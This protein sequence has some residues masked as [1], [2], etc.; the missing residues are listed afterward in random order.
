MPLTWN[1]CD[2]NLLLI[3]AAG[4]GVTSA[5]MLLGTVAATD[6]SDCHL[7]VIDGRGDQAL[8]GFEHSPWCGGVVRLHERERL[9]RLINRLADE[10]ARRN[11]RSDV[12]PRHPIVVL[13]DGLDI[14]RSSLDDLETAAEFEML[15]TI[16]ALG[17]AHDVVV[18]E[19]VRSR[20]GHP[21]DG[22]GPL[23]PALGLPP[24]RSD[25]RRRAGDLPGRG[26]GAA[27]GQDRRRL[28]RSRGAVDGRLACRCRRAPAVWSPSPVEC[29]PAMLDAADLPPASGEA[30]TRC[31]RSAC[32]SVTA[33][34]AAS[35]CP[36]ANT[37]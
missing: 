37:C 31:C 6:G 17:A 4:S 14:V 34:C 30:T 32:T 7:Y 28:H 1:R 29:L 23:R 20:R 19:H 21:V 3:G 35:T 12:V 15:D 10:I 18:V 13:V 11:G 27:A 25:R 8:A 16:V 33:E 36:T 5:L 9:I 24:D 2:G 26:A 22:A